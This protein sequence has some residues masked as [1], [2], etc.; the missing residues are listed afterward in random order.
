VGCVMQMDSGG[1]GGR[2]KRRHMDDED[3]DYDRRP[4]HSNDVFRAR[5]QERLLR[6]YSNS[7]V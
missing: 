7:S 2:R 6:T 5:Q 4:M 1:G 3:D